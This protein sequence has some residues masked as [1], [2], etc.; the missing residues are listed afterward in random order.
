MPDQ[1][2]NPHRV[3]CSIVCFSV[4]IVIP[5]VFFLFFRAAMFYGASDAAW[6]FGRYIWCCC[7]ALIG[8][9]GL[10]YAY[11]YEPDKPYWQFLTWQVP[12]VLAVSALIFAGLH[13]YP[14]PSGPLF[15]YL[16]AGLCV[17]M[18]YSAERLLSLFQ[19]GLDRLA[20]K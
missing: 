19:G 16:S 14:A 3:A 12:L 10:V 18:G 11:R 20:K 9:G 7:L 15:Y 1:K 8:F 17:P 5:A 4:G 6:N 13:L 2:A